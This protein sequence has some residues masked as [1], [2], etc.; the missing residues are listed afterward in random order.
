MKNRIAAMEK[1]TGR[2]S[3]IRARKNRR[4]KILLI[5]LCILLALILFFSLKHILFFLRSSGGDDDI[6]YSV[7]GIDVS[8]YQKEIDWNG[9]EDEGVKFAFIR[10]T[11]GT[12][13]VDERFAYNWKEAHRTDMKIGAYHFLS[14]NTSGE[15]Q[16][17]NFIDTVDKKRGMMPPVIDVELSGKYLENPPT[18]EEMYAILDVVIEML[19]EEYGKIP[20]IY[21]NRNIYRKYIAG[22]YDR[23]P[24]WIS[25]P[26]GIP[27][28]LPDGRDWLFCQ[29]T[30]TGTSPSIGGGEVH[31]DYNVFN[32]SNWDFMR[33]NGK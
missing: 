23:H 28:T 17:Q 22:R 9:L 27:K 25:C 18:K 7:R 26:D 10:A 33:Y 15:T 1:T 29:Y 13:I 30:F 4:N 3:N 14:Y 19:E 20:I 21:T 31:V 16:A 11:E 2:S 8:F 5:T 12:T 32:G 6:P 24:V